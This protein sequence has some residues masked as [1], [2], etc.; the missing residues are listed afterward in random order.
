MC[1]VDAMPVNIRRC[2]NSSMK[3]AIAICMVN[4]LWM[5]IFTR[6]ALLQSSSGLRDDANDAGDRLE[7]VI[8]IQQRSPS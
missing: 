1:V 8:I 4:Y 5:L 3:V 6:T 7:D 2:P